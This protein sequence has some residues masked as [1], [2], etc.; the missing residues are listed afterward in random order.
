[1]TPD[2]RRGRILSSSARG[3]LTT[4]ASRAARL[5]GSAYL[6]HLALRDGWRNRFAGFTQGVDVQSDAFSN[7][8]QHLPPRLRHGDAA[9][10]I[11]NV[12]AVAGLALLNNNQVF[13]AAAPINDSLWS[14]EI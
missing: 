10:Q 3:G 13:H 9:R 12:C 5:S 8:L 1:M 4:H 2:Q 14:R 6:D 7:E 11:W